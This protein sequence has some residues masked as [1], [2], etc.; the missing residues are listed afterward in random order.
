MEDKA[1]LTYAY[2]LDTSER[3]VKFEYLLGENVSVVGGQDY[4][5]SVG[6]DLKFRFSF[7]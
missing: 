1:F 7:E 2:T 4:T 5:G 3:E 6:G